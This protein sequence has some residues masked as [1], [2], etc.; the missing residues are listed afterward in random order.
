MIEIY[1]HGPSPSCCSATMSMNCK[2]KPGSIANLLERVLLRVEAYCHG[3]ST[4]KTTNRGGGDTGKHSVKSCKELR[5]AFIAAGEERQ[6]LG[7]GGFCRY[8]TSEADRARPGQ[9][10]T[11]RDSHT[12]IPSDHVLHPQ[13]GFPRRMLLEFFGGLSQ[14]LKKYIQARTASRSCAFSTSSVARK[15]MPDA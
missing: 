14:F 6:S 7:T 5:S 1:L 15:G 12:L 2:D 3:C 11:D 13:A 10:V 9:N 4:R 8:S